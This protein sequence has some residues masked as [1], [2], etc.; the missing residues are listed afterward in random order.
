MLHL[1]WLVGANS[2][3]PRAFTKSRHS[4]QIYRRPASAIGVRKSL[5][6]SIH[7]RNWR[8][9]MKSSAL[10]LAA[11]GATV[12]CNVMAEVCLTPDGYVVEC[13]TP[14]NP[15]VASQFSSL[16]S[17]AGVPTAIYLT[18]GRPITGAGGFTVRIN[19]QFLCYTGDHAPGFDP[20][21][22]VRT[23]TA[24]VPVPG[25]YTFDAI[26]D[27]GTNWSPPP[28]TVRTVN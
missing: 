5:G 2:G 19:K 15:H 23:C 10:L 18:G 8:P 28:I 26:P 7:F 20:G 21:T 12:S 17:Q 27:A 14:G 3:R 24:T 9:N 22:P 13:A 1:G 4:L 11:V 16:P 25:T 6:A